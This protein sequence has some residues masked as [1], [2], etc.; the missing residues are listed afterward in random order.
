MAFA[1]IHPDRREFIADLAEDVWSTFSG[2]R[3]VFVDG[4]IKSVGVGLTYDDYEDAF[5]GLIEYRSGRFHIFS[6]TTQGQQPNFP[7][8][9]FTL[10]HELAHYFIDEH[11]IKLRSGVPPIHP[12][13]IVR[14]KMSR[15]RKRI[16]LLLICS[17]RQRSFQKH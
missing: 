14:Q 6:N 7:R 13:R 15:N 9:R 5:D 1:E 8:V 10:G 4:I 17:C 12:T 16:C 3:Q 2:E 11:R